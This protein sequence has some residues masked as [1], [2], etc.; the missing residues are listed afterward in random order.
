LMEKLRK[1]NYERKGGNK[2]LEKMI[3]KASLSSLFL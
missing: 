3:K 2:K 1:L